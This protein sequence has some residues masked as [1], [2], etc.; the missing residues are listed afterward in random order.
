VGK[1]Y[2]PTEQS[3]P[4]KHKNEVKN[5]KR[6][7]RT[8]IFAAESLLIVAVLGLGGAR[9]SPVAQAQSTSAPSIEGSWF[10]TV[11]PPQGG[12][13]PFK[14]LASF[15]R[16]GVF[17]SSTQNDQLS[18]RKAS[19]QH[20]SWMR[21]SDSFTSTEYSFAYDAAGNPVGLFKIHA[22]YRLSG[23][24]QLEGNGSQAFCDLN[25]ENCFNFPGCARIS[26][27]RIQVEP[28]SCP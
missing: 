9:F 21:T 26:G 19:E 13:P 20:G 4:R 3:R 25:G 10:F 1:K 2:F 17:T 18:T 28:P 8:V 11:T 5:M 7:A 6:N 22:Q 14:A 15:A 27:T 16:G 12:P 23:N 24:D